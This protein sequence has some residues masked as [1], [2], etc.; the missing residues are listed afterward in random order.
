M[1]QD[2]KPKKKWYKRWWAFVLYFFIFIIII[3]GSS[4]GEQS[5][6]DQVS[7]NEPQAQ[8]QEVQEPV[9]QKQEASVTK[10]EASQQAPVKT[11]QE[12]KTPEPTPAPVHEEVK[13]EPKPQGK[14]YQHIFTFSG[15]GAKKSEPFI[16]TGSRFKIKYDC[17]GDFCQAFLKSTANEY[18]LDIIMNSVESVKDETILYGAGEYYIDANILGSYTMTVEDYR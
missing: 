16:I 13:Q 5:D 12:V 3:A 10:T 15:N 2:N 6:T 11:Q 18:D 14:T 4:D 1:S 8:V 9:T 17:K 7:S